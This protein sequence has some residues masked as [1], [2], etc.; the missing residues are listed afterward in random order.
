MLKIQMQYF[1]IF[2]LYNVYLFYLIFDNNLKVMAI[3]ILIDVR[4]ENYIESGKCA[5]RY[6]V[7][8]GLKNQAN[9]IYEVR[10][11]GIHKM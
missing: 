5:K 2:I 4:G 8:N 1:T 10:Y 7:S 3:L 11:G 9:G 6:Y